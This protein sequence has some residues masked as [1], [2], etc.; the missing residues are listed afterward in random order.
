[1]A[2]HLWVCPTSWRSAAGAR[3]SVATDGDRLLHALLASDRPAELSQTGHK[4]LKA[5]ASA[6]TE[7]PAPTQRFSRSTERFIDAEVTSEY[8]AVGSSQQ[9]L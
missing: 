2:Q 1:M 9:V 3:G 6:N 7:L 8:I 4:A 5:T